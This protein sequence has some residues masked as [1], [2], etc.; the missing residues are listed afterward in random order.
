VAALRRCGYR[1]YPIGDPVDLL[2]GAHGQIHLLE[3]KDP[4]KPPSA[5]R[6]TPAQREFFSYWDGYPVHVVTTAE[7]ALQAVGGC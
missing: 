4:A 3:I 2:V 5:R 6:L 7:A 1:V